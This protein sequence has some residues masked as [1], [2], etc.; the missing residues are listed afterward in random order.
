M[1][2]PTLRIEPEKIA[3]KAEIRLD[4]TT[5]FTVENHGNS[6]IW[7]GFKDAATGRAI[8]LAPGTDRSFTGSP[9]AVFTGALI[10]DFDETTVPEGVAAINSALIIKQIIT[11]CTNK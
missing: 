3:G 10:V 9:G 8:D 7:L 1:S 4:S 6:T 2:Y 5:G 11:P